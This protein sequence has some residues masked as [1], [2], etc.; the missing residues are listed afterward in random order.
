MSFKDF[1]SQ[2]IRGWLPEE[3]EMQKS[4]FRKLRTPL[5]F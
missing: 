5:A 4:T 2:S 3:P 1:F